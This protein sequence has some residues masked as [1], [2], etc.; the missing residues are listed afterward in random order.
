MGRQS[1]YTLEI[2]GEAVAA[3]HSVAGVL[4]YLGVRW[5]GGSHAH[6]SRRIKHYGI[7]TTHFT[8][9]AHLKGGTSR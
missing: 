6:I 1:K 4:R 9:A 3:S 2:L 7:D 5:T 8:G